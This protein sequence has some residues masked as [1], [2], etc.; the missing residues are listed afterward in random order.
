MVPVNILVAVHGHEPAGWTLEVP[1]VIAAHGFARLR[2]L[3]VIDA[4]PV[5]FT[6]LV[7]AAR[8]RFDA[9]LAETR[10]RENTR[11]SATVGELI[12][13]LP[14]PPE[15]Q[16]VRTWRSDAARSIVGHAALWRAD[17]VIVGRDG[18]S[19][20]Q[21]AGLDAVHE[22]VVRLAA[23]AVLVIPA[24]PVATSARPRI[25]RIGPVASAEQN[26]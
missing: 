6:S 12:A 19:R 16:R 13:A 4:P 7:P 22:R 5:A 17:V 11:V 24:P 9:A 26:P 2:L 3:M 8:R 10:E 14:F 25:R 18:R 21:R 1:R 15:V 23:C 20:L